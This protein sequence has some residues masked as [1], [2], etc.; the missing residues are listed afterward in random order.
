MSIVIF[1]TWESFPPAAA[2]LVECCGPFRRPRMLLAEK[3]LQGFS[4]GGC[5]GPSWDRVWLYGHCLPYQQYR[6]RWFGKL[7][8]F[9][10]SWCFPL[11]NCIYIYYI[12]YIYIYM[13]FY[14][15]AHKLSYDIIWLCWKYTSL[16]SPL[17]M[18]PLN[19]WHLVGGVS[20]IFRHAFATPCAKAIA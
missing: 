6:V 5:L 16:N 20:T 1:G 4:E 18:F 14:R 12:T 7:L 9:D 3:L 13:F 15:F 2:T 17:I 8:I 19:N 10:W 11:Y